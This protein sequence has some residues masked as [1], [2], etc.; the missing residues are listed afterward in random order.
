M[1]RDAVE[2]LLLILLC[3]FSGFALRRRDVWRR[4]RYL[5]GGIWLL[6][7]AALLVAVGF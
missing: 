7:G 1:S 6:L 3:G 5:M 2:L 4:R